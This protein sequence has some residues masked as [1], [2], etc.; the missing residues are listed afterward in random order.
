VT[1]D[2]PFPLEARVEHAEWGAGTVVR[3]EAD[4]VVVLFDESGY[5]TLAV[6]L[7]VERDLLKPA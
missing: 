3:Y 7:V 6:P 4:T 2:E 5:R 1:G